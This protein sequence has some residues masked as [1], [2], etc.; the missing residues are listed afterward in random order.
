MLDLQLLRDDPE[1]VRRAIRHKNAG[2]PAVVDRLLEAD[3]ERRAALTALQTLQQQQGE[4]SRQIGPLMKAGR[5]DEAAPLLERSN[6][7]K[8]EIQSLQEAARAHEEAVNALLLEIPNV[9]HESVPIGRTAEDNA[10][11]FEW[12][13]KPAFDFEAKPH[14]DLAAQHRLI[15]FEA[16]AKVTG[17]GFPF[18]LGQGARLQRALIQFFLD[19]AVE[20]GYTEVQPPLLV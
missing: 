10:I 13:E 1:R 2:D 3:R 17:A 7:L 18:Y 15:D 4:V 8:A 20:A 5:K 12:G 6:A 11:P 16:G 9:P 14:W 19:R